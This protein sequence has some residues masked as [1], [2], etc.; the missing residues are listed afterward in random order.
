MR[1]L[2]KRPVPGGVHALRGLNI[3]DDEL[4]ALVMTCPDLTYINLA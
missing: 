4:I 1:G 3:T 2:N